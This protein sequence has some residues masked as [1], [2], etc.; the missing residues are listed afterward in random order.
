VRPLLESA[1][2]ACQAEPE[3]ALRSE[4]VLASLATV[5][6][7]PDRTEPNP[8]RVRRCQGWG[9]YWRRQKGGKP[10]D[11]SLRVEY[12]ASNDIFQL[13]TRRGWT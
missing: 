6:P 9:R 7:R 11:D 2:A 5:L 13:K 8:F 3:P 10:M 4:D 1:A 12:S